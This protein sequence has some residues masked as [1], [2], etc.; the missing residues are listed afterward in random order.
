MLGVVSVQRRLWAGQDD[1]A[2]VLQN[3]RRARGAG[4]AVQPGDE[5]AGHPSL[6]GQELP[7]ALA[8]AGLGAGKVWGRGSAQQSP[9][10]AMEEDALGAGQGLGVHGSQPRLHPRSATPRAA[11][12]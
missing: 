12:A 5:A 8:G 6:R 7:V 3:Q 1:P 9:R 10:G 2:R 11:G 4:V